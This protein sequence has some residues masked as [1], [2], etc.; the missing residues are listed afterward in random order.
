MRQ[1]RRVNL[2]SED[3]NK[4]MYYTLKKGMDAGIYGMVGY[5]SSDLNGKY[6]KKNLEYTHMK[7]QP[8]GLAHEKCQ[9][10]I[11]TVMKGDYGRD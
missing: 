6:H 3:I 1:A 11:I 5:S 8:T 9:A 10:W 2:N 4:K 7:Y